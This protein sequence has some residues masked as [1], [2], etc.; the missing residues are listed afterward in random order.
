M[1]CIEQLVFVIG[2]KCFFVRQE[3]NFL[4]YVLSKDATGFFFRS[5]LC[6]FLFV[7]LSVC[8]CMYVCTYVYVRMCTY[9]SIGYVHI[10]TCVRTYVFP[11]ATTSIST[12]TSVAWFVGNLIW[13][14]LH[15]KI[16][17][18][19]SFLFLTRSSNMAKH[20]ILTHYTTYSSSLNN[21]S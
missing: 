17:H 16:S 21:L 4:H 20:E 9:V 12:S 1:N 19:C 11:Y 13:T 7:C 3:L 6:A 2:K 15:Y 8:L 18:C 14:L 5:Q 10:C